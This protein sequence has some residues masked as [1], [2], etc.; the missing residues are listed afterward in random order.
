MRTTKLLMINA[1]KWAAFRFP[2]HGWM[3][4]FLCVII[5][6]YLTLDLL[7]GH[8]MSLDDGEVFWSLNEVLLSCRLKE[9]IDQFFF[10]FLHLHVGVKMIVNEI[11]SEFFLS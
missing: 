10:I 8:G 5:F 1:L 7:Q 3:D 2:M 6:K 11:L 4:A 9:F